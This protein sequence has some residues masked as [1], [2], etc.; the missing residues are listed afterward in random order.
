MASIEKV[1]ALATETLVENDLSRVAVK[2]EDFEIELERR[3]APPPFMANMPGMHFTPPPVGGMPPFAPVGT[4]DGMNPTGAAT[5]KEAPGNIVK[6]PII[7]TFYESSAPG[8]PPFVKIGDRVQ[9]GD[10][11]FIIESMKLMNEVTS[12]FDGEIAEIMVQ[13][14]N[15]IE[16]DEP[17]MRII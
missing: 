5:P 2:T 10:V 16:Y 15:P 17:V 9:K 4:T 3:P 14:G 7:G 8:K 12:E 11:L 1:M 6:A 13:N